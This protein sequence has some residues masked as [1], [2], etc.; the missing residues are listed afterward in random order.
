MRQFPSGK[1]PFENE[2]FAAL[3]NTLILQSFA[4]R[5]IALSSH[6]YDQLDNALQGVAKVL[7]VS[8]IRSWQYMIRLSR[9]MSEGR[10]ARDSSMPLDTTMIK[11]ERLKQSMDTLVGDLRFQL[12][13]T[14]AE[15]QN[16]SVARIIYAVR[17]RAFGVAVA[18]Q[19]ILLCVR[20]TLSPDDLVLDLEAMD[21]CDQALTIANEARIHRPHGAV[22]TVHTLICTW[23]AVRD[24]DLRA[25]I[26]GELV[27]Y[28]R[29]A[30]GPT[31]QL[32]LDQLKLLQR[33]LSLCE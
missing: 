13:S 1:D 15:Y 20:R 10:D 3:C 4:N 22:W 7:G 14:Y 8:E 21:L 17:H 5:E 19:A 32:Q 16:P 30:T 12:E 6:E 18:A 26:E 9:L 2:L 31:F 24:T 25:K 27:D 29:D 23:C 33:R 11:A 28:H